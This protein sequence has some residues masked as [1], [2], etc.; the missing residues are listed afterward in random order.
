M[1]HHEEIRK[2]LLEQISAMRPGERIPNELHLAEYFGVSRMTVNKVITELAK[3]GFLN[4]KRGIGSFVARK[5]ASRKIVT[6]LLPSAMNLPAEL[7]HIIS[8]AAE[9]A[10]KMGVGIELIA[11]S[12]DNSKDHID[13]SA[14]EHLSEES[15]VV[16]VSNWFYRIFPFLRERKCRTLLIDRQLLQFAPEDDSIRDFQILDCNV[17]E[18]VH[19]AFQRLY[20]SGCR[21]IAF[22]GVKPVLQS[23]TC[24][25][26]ELELEQRKMSGCLM[27][28]E[29][30]K[31]R[32]TA[33]EL[34]SIRRFNADGLIYDASYVR[35]LSGSDFRSI[36]NIPES[37][38]CEFV[39]FNPQMNFLD[40]TP[41]AGMINGFKVGENAVSMLLDP[42][43]PMY[44]LLSP[45]YIPESDTL[46]LKQNINF[47]LM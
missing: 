25:F 27:A 9:T 20:D 12:P 26:Y 2:E 38:K 30:G 18:M 37:L 24:H 7:Q 40:K 11:V 42:A 46:K 15:L 28:M 31:F 16:A 8:G 22:C 43:K 39:R 4:R 33:E 13:F 14:I 10:R 29:N 44:R 3:E 32:L 6:I 41:S 45:E 47:E 19:T 17:Q 23:I 34:D 5:R 1:T 36:I 21:R 35:S